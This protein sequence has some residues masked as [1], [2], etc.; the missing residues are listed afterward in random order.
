MRS[1][2]SSAARDT[3]ERVCMSRAWLRS[4]SK[5]RSVEGTASTNL[6]KPRGAGASYA[7]DLLRLAAEAGGAP[8]GE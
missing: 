4:S 8:V 7:S 3:S 2:S 5:A 1:S 6:P